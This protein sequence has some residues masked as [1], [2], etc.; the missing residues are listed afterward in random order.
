VLFRT[1]LKIG[2]ELVNR[3]VHVPLPFRAVVADSFYGEDRSFR[4]GLQDLGVGYVLALKP[5]HAWYHPEMEIGSFQE[6]AKASGME[7]SRTSRSLDQDHADV[8]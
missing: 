2:V 3:A 5:S 6:A 7:T 4:R 1:K 8:S